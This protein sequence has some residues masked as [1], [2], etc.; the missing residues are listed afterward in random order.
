MNRESFMSFFRDE[1]NLNLLSPDDR[2]EIFSQILAG[3][4][5]FSKELL[6]Q[7][8]SD[9]CVDFLEVNEKRNE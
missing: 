1:E 9:Y 5:D 8:F 7:V 4:S 6:D 2:I 3:S